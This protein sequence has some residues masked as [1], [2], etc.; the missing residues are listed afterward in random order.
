MDSTAHS[1]DLLWQEGTPHDYIDTAE[2]VLQSATSHLG[3]AG[4]FPVERIGTWRAE[5]FRLADGTLARNRSVDAMMEYARLDAISSGAQAGQ[6]L[7]QSVN[8]CLVWHPWRPETWDGFPFLIVRDDYVMP[9]EEYVFG[10]AIPYKCAT[11][12]TF[13]YE[14]DARIS[15]RLAAFAAT[16][17]HEFGHVLGAPD[18]D[19]GR[20]IEHWL[21]THCTNACVMRQRDDLPEWEAEI[22][23]DMFE[24]KLYCPLCLR[25]IRAFVRERFPT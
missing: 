9:T 10:A 16:V 4:R 24:G 1:I 15:D 17:Y 13:R 18:S 3:I 19:R 14:R 22:V 5:D 25:D 7:T 23:K 2:K 11:V 8:P 6:A 20:D 12:S 21:G